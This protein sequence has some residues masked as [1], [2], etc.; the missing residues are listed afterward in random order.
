MSSDLISCD[1]QQIGFWESC[2]G[3]RIQVTR[4]TQALT[5]LLHPAPG[6]FSAAPFRFSTSSLILFVS[7]KLILL[8][9]PISVI[10]YAPLNPQRSRQKLI[11]PGDGTISKEQWMEMR[12]SLPASPQ[13][14][15]RYS[16]PPHRR[17]LASWPLLPG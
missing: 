13:H 1:R 9:V 4:R 6:D 7:C 16:R 12:M 2:L 5:G 11:Y 17:M 3:Q 15:V 8:M 14:G 10:H